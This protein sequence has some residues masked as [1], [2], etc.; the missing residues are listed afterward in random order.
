MSSKLQLWDGWSS[1]SAERPAA[2]P[3]AHLPA[4]P[5]AEQPQ[6]LYRRETLG[7]SRARAAEGCEPFSLQWYLDIEH[8]RHRRHARWLPSVLEFNKHSGETLLG[9][10][11]GLGTDWV[12]FARHGASVTV[13]SPSAE[14][15]AL[16]RQNFE[17]RQ[18]PG[19]FVQAMHTSL[20]L[21]AASI[22]VVCMD[23]LLQII[24]DP[25]GLIDEV[26]RVLKPGGKVMA[27]AP[28]RYNIDFW[29]HLL[30]PWSWRLRPARKPSSHPRFTGRELRGL[31]HRFVEHR[32]HK[33]HLRRSDVPH[34]WRL[35]PTSML[36]RMTG[37][38]LILKAFKPLSSAIVVPMAA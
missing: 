38:L 26:Y 12:Q 20:P 15:L 24:R 32:V 25:Q 30:I 21:E 31:F 13:C 1:G 28:A 9:L 2:G 22:D 3:P 7:P 4:S 5:G 6:Q 33:R 8:A 27:V 23:D 34:V 35:L 18:L 14:Q 37:R 36:E 16:V 10:G 11:T 17:L 29:R 19:R